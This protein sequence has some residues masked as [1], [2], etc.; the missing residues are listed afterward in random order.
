MSYG[1]FL[2][3]VGRM[4]EAVDQYERARAMM[5]LAPFTNVRLAQALFIVGRAEEAKKVLTQT[6]NMWPDA[7]SLR[8]LK[9]KSALWTRDYD[10]A[11]AMLGETGMHLSDAQ[12]DAL[13]SAFAAL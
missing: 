10:R 7:T 12:K 1:D 4:E 13:A 5:P 9:L 2:A 8:L 6:L 3:S 11:V